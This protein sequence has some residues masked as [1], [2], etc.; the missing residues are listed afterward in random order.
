[1]KLGPPAAF[2]TALIVALAAA[3]AS[4]AEDLPVEPLAISK[5]TTWITEPLRSDGTRTTRRGSPASTQ[6]A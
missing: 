6:R 2:G 3:T 4:P 5:A 1:M